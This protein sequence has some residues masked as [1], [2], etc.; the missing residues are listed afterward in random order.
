MAKL[1]QGA[2]AVVTGGAR[3]IGLAVAQALL[4]SGVKV[5]ALDRPGADFTAVQSAASRCGVEC[6]ILRA[7]VRDQAAVRLAVLGATDIGL[8]RYAVNCAGIDGLAPSDEVTSE[9]WKRVVDVDLDGVFFA[10]Q[11]EHEA[12]RGGSGSIVNIASMSG[13]IVN[14]GVDPHVAYGAAKAGV[15][16]LSKGLGVEWASG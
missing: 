9:A 3:G 10:C 6:T 1:E 8:V 2:V 4:S 5:A 16:H 14:R 7:D 13:H 12:M 15:I 11:A